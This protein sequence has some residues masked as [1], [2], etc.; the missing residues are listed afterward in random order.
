MSLDSHIYTII[1]P[2][3]KLETLK[4][5]SLGESES[6]D[7]NAKLQGYEHPYIM[8]NGYTFQEGGVDMFSLDLNGKF[9]E[10]RV[11]LID[12]QDVFTVDM[13]PRDGDTLSLR[14]TGDTTETFKDIRMDFNIVEFRGQPTNNYNKVSGKNTFVVRAIARIPGIYSEECKSYGDV[15]SLDQLKSICSDLGLG[16]ATNVSG[17]NDQMRRLNPYQTVMSM[18]E[19]S[20]LH[21]YVSDDSFQTFC[22]DPY[23]YINFVDVQRVLNSENKIELTDAITSHNSRTRSEDP[24]DG[25]GKH[26]RDLIL[27]NHHVDAGF[28]NFIKTYNIVNNSTRIALENGYRRS[29]QYFDYDD[30][31]VLEFDVE[32]LTS[33]NLKDIEEP[34]KGKRNSE[35]DEYDTHK[36][37]KYMGVQNSN[38]H[39]NYKYSAINNIQ[40]L[41]EL[42]KMY[43]EVELGSINPSVYKYMKVPVAIY[44]YSR[45]SGMVDNIKNRKMKEDG[46]E[47]DQDRSEVGKAST[48]D[49]EGQFNKAETYDSFISGYYVVV[50]I[51]YRYN[52]KSG[53]TQKLKLA[54][55]EWPARVNNV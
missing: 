53:Y 22:I 48:A 23:Y 32:S 43:L 25:S 5:S 27:S 4:V 19:E 45:T 30:D 37:H 14:I 36:K 21:S 55:R 31:S 26:Q 44:N 9:P 46:F 49:E 51:Q 41:V 12:T 15:S 35:N 11:Q 6:G 54:R 13:L 34:L 29:T 2:K 47:L 52:P 18:L 42:D 8:I 10:V 24:D 38:V 17:T 39:K 1:E 7:Q 3:I 33:D 28:D 50:G 20:V 40:N 16:L